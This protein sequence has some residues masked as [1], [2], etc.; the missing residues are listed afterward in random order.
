MKVNYIVF[1]STIPII[2]SV[3]RAGF[4]GTLKIIINGNNVIPI[5]QQAYYNSNVNIFFYVADVLVED[6]KAEESWQAY[7]NT[8]KI[9]PI[10]EYTE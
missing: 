1:P 4:S 8:D 10:S 5:E 3:C 7:F 2:P 9:L 6:Y